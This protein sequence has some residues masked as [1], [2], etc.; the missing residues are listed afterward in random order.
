MISAVPTRG[1]CNGPQLII[2]K[3]DVAKAGGYAIWLGDPWRIETVEGERGRRPW[4]APPP[5]VHP[6][7]VN[8][9]E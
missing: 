4:S 3:F 6:K 2:D 1:F 5:R 7:P 9:A 8:T